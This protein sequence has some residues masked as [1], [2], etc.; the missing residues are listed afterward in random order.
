MKSNFAMN[1]DWTHRFAQMMQ[2][3]IIQTIN[4]TCKA[5]EYNEEWE[6]IKK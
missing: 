6:K 4:E 3:I 1:E 2:R 5:N